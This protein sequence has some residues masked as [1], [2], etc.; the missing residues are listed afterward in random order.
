MA[1]LRHWG[2]HKYDEISPYHKDYN[3]EYRIWNKMKDRCLNPKNDMFSLYGGRGIRICSEWLDKKKGFINFYRDMGARPKDK[4]GHN[5]QIDRKDP[6]GDYCPENCHWVE[7][8]KNA[9]NK[10]TSKFIYLFGEKY[11]ITEAC[12]LFNIKRTTV[13][14]AVRLGRRS[15]EDA[16]ATE[17]ERRK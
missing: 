1:E 5:Y 11:C 10:R 6:D 4:N 15:L 16:F 3:G 14:E 13:T 2:H 12:R 9:Q 7:P 17:L 8:I